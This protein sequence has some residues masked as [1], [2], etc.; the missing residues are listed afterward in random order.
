[1][2]KSVFFSRSGR[3]LATTIALV[4]TYAAVTV[5]SALTGAYTEI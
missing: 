3:V 2:R 1:M 5:S 4:L